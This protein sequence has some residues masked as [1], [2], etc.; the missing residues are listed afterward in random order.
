MTDSVERYFGR[1]GE[2]MRCRRCGCEAELAQDGVFHCHAPPSW[3]QRFPLPGRQDV[4]SSALTR[5]EWE[6]PVDVERLA[7]QEEG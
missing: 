7:I 4:V 3:C 5:L 6:R 2:R 1:A